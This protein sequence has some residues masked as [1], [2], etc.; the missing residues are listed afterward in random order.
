[1]RVTFVA[2]L[3]VLGLGR[4]Q[5]GG[6]AADA[7]ITLANVAAEAYV[8]SA[9]AGENVAELGEENAAWTLQVGHR[10][11][12]VN[13]GGLFHPLELRG[14]EDVLLAQGAPTGTFEDD[15]AVAFVS[16]E[17]GVRFTLTPALAEVL[18]RYRCTFHPLM[19]GEI[20]VAG[21]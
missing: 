21:P 5:N 3:L 7:T 9:V 10:Y 4:A 18:R 14:D 17:A 12:I 2:V 8:L 11:H 19:T 6:A 20:T 1:M 15:P 13:H 16:D